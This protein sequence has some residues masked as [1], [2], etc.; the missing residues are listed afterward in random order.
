[1]KTKMR[2]SLLAISFGLALFVTSPI[3]ADTIEGWWGG[4]W[5]CKIDGRPARMKWIPAEGGSGL[6]WKGS[7]SDNGSRW[8]PLTN[9]RKGN[10]GGLYFNHADGNKWYLAKP[11]GHKTSGWTTWN[12]QRYPLSCWH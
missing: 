10:Q 5:A 3:S 6:Y 12:G 11:A 4:N 7:F 8:V 1:M 9:A 2:L